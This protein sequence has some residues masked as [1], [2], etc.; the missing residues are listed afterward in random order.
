MTGETY[1]AASEDVIAEDFDGECVIL[2]L[3]NG[4]Y[5]SMGAGAALVWKAVLAGYAPAHLAAALPD[6]A[7]NAAVHA[8]VQTL[9]GHGLIVPAERERKDSVEE[10]VTALTGVHPDFAIEAF[11]DLADLLIADPVHDVDAAVGWPPRP[12]GDG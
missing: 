11:G 9:L 4:T 7:L 8:S 12:S 3:R 2:D 6:E 5:F 10:L 1:A